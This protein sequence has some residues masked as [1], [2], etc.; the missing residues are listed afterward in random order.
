M[1]EEEE[2]GEIAT[3]PEWMQTR[4]SNCLNGWSH[5]LHPS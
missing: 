3:A 4:W 2:E 1:E 5:L